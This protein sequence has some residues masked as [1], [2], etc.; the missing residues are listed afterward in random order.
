MAYEDLWQMKI[1]LN[2]IGIHYSKNK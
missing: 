1:F 2:T